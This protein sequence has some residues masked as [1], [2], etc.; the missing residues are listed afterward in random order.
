M[1]AIAARTQDSATQ[2]KPTP[3]PPRKRLPFPGP[4]PLPPAASSARAEILYK[5]YSEQ[6][7]R[8]A[9]GRLWSYEYDRRADLTC[10]AEDVTHETFVRW[11]E[12]AREGY[13]LPP[14]EDEQYQRN[15]LLHIAP[16]PRCLRLNPPP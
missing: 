13:P 11:L 6:V 16:Y 2:A 15:F 4:A 8:F 1:V 12:L 3:L 7:R 10:E 14:A 5:V 9:Y